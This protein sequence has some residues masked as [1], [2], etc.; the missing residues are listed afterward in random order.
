M[1]MMMTRFSGEN[2][3]F[4]EGLAIWPYALFAGACFL[5]QYLLVAIFLDPEFPGLLGG[6]IGLIIII[7]ATR[8][9]FLVP[10]KTWDFPGRENWM[11]EWTGSISME[12]RS[13]G[14]DISLLKA[15]IPYIF[16]GILLVITRIRSLPLGRVLQSAGIS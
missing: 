9:G 5:V 4:K 12:S 13:V 16:I 10:K 8:A 11:K 3:T 1:V 2:R 15:W 7:P 6:L 14:K